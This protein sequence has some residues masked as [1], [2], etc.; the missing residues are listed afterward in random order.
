MAI[1]VC[2]QKIGPFPFV[3]L[4][5]AQF[6]A[7]SKKIVEIEHTSCLRQSPGIYGPQLDSRKH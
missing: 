2:A 4:G 5:V 6:G 7:R 1:Q 3:E